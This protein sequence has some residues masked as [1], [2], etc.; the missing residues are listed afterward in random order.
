MKTSLYVL[1]YKLKTVKL[2]VALGLAAKVL[3]AV[4]GIAQ[5]WVTGPLCRRLML[6]AAA[7]VAVGLSS[8]VMQRQKTALKGRSGPGVTAMR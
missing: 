8:R 1:K 5:I 7:G 2:Q 4:M 6:S 3:M